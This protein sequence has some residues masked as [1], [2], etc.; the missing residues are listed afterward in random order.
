VGK[1]LE[2]FVKSISIFFMTWVSRTCLH[3]WTCVK[4]NQR[5][6]QETMS[7]FSLKSGVSFVLFCFALLKSKCDPPAVDPGFPSGWPSMEL[8]QDVILRRVWAGKGP[9]TGHSTLSKTVFS[10]IAQSC[11][12]FN[13]PYL[14]AHIVLLESP[15]LSLALCQVQNR[16]LIHIGSIHI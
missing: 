6:I 9:H 13:L 4:G 12:V 3:L 14:T 10:L 5:V 16:Y 1:H 7:Y 8:S 11:L 2:A 15:S